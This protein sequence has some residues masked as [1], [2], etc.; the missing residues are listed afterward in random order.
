MWCLIDAASLHLCDVFT[1]AVVME[2]DTP[3]EADLVSSWPVFPAHTVASQLFPITFF[4]LIMTWGGCFGGVALGKWQD[5]LSRFPPQVS[6]FD[7]TPLEFRFTF[8]KVRECKE[9]RTQ[10]SLQPSS[11]PNTCTWRVD[12]WKIGVCV[13]VWIA[14]SILGPV[15]CQQNTQIYLTLTLTNLLLNFLSLLA[16]FIR[17]DQCQKLLGSRLLIFSQHWPLLS[18]V[19]MTNITDG[20]LYQLKLIKDNSIMAKMKLL[21]VLWLVCSLSVLSQRLFVS[22]KTCHSVTSLYDHQ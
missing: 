9:G 21:A 11:L 4:L 7:D 17:K 13:W 20:G 15:C 10:S 6:L 3:A 5:L 14:G 8:E 19:K 1:D 16:L 18:L 22:V 2:W 12:G